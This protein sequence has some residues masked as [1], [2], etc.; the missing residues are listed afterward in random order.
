LGALYEFLFNKSSRVSPTDIIPSVKI[1]LHAIPVDSNVLVWFGHSSYL[2]QIDGKR[3][4]V[5]PIFSGNASPI[6][7]TTSAFAGT[8]RYT[9][10]DLPEIDYLFISHDHYD[11]VDYTT[12]LELKSKVKTVVCGLGV[13]AHFERWGYDSA[14]VQ[15]KD[16]YDE[17]KLDSGFVA[18][19][20]PARHFSGRSFS[21][22]NTLWTS[23][24]IQTPTLKI[25][26]GG[27]SGYDSHFAEIG[28]RFGPFDLAIIENGQYNLRWKYIHTQPEQVLQAAHD[29]K[30]RRLFP[31]HSSKFALAS[32]AWDEPLTRVTELNSKSVNPLYM[33]TPVIGEV[34]NLNDSTQTFKHWWKGIN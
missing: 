13:G 14:K 1:D 34:V 16:W 11:H 31:V 23:Y 26:I 25:Y 9:V 8:D 4:L 22:N 19:S 3:I 20:T 2:I 18:Y 30:A 27:D 6:P 15:E 21:R 28:N 10:A 32:H 12:L 24:V 33:L 5:D 7:G 17:V 29:L